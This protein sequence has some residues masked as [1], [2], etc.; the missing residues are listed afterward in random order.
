VIAFVSE[1]TVRARRGGQIRVLIVDEDETFVEECRSALELADYEVATADL[2]DI[3]IVRR[4]L[5][6]IMVVAVAFRGESLGLDFL[7][8]HMSDART[9]SVP[10]ILRESAAP[11]TIDQ[12]SRAR[13]LGALVIPHTI[14]LPALVEQI[15]LQI[16]RSVVVAGEKT[17]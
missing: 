1:E 15:R 9:A 7:E 8:H 5:P 16:G 11:S 13:A 6:D 12:E 17:A 4:M 10:V 14:E 3:G 2:P